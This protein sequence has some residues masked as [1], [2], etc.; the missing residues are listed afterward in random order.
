MD[1]GCRFRV[2]LAI[3]VK[4]RGGENMAPK[5][6]K[7]NKKHKSAQ[8]FWLFRT[9]LCPTHPKKNSYVEALTPSSSEWDCIWKQGPKRGD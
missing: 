2:H 6:Q 1:L 5:K 8:S 3:K 9:E 7:K 4:A